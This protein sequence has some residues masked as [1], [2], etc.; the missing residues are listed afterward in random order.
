MS[1]I[2]N[3]KGFRWPPSNFA[4]Y[5]IHLSIGQ[6]SIPMCD[7]SLWISHDSGI[8]NTLLSPLYSRHYIHSLK[9][10]LLRA[11]CF[12]RTFFT[13]LFS[14]KDYISTSYLDSM[15]LWS[16]KRRKIDYPFTFTSFIPPKTIYINSFCMQLL[17]ISRKP[18]LHSILSWIG[19]CPMTLF[20]LIFQ[21]R[22]GGNSLLVLI[23]KTTSSFFKHMPLTVKFHGAVLH[24]NLHKSYQ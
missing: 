20:F 4:I 2:W 15:A 7:S 1:N 10:W 19:L 17:S 23:L 12:L 11:F 6:V 3:L 18:Y 5:N 24:C 21:Y 14:H 13:Q 22:A 16:N 9:Q 8:T